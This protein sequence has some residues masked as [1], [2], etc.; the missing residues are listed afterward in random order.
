MRI[1]NFIKKGDTIAITAPSDGL[2]EVTDH[3][4]LDNAKNNLIERGYK[5]IENSRPVLSE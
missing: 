3:I 4:R 5:V 2:K 1:P